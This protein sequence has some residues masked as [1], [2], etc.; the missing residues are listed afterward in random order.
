M[1]WSTVFCAFDVPDC[2]L[3]KAAFVNA[4]VG[5]QVAYASYVPPAS[6]VNVHVAMPFP[7]FGGSW[8]QLVYPACAVLTF[9]LVNPG[10]EKPGCPSLIVGG[11]DASCARRE[12]VTVAARAT[13]ETT[14]ADASNRVRVKC[15]IPVWVWM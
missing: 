9:V 2:A 7:D 4:G 10:A 13:A 5:Y 12:W 6:C 15:C 1:L 8:T 14:K 3:Y 11:V